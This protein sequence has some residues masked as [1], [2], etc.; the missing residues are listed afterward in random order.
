AA[1]SPARQAVR[2]ASSSRSSSSARC[3]IWPVRA[4][5]CS[6]QRKSSSATFNAA[7][8]ASRVASPVGVDAAAACLFSSTYA[9]SR[10]AY[11]G[12][13]VLRIGYRCP[14]I[15]TGITRPSDIWSLVVRRWSLVVGRSS[16]VARQRLEIQRFELPEHLGHA[17]PDDV[18]LF[19]ERRELGR[20]R[21]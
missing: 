3:A 19:L 9:A 1:T 17:R 18:A 6:R 7:S 2:T 10:P 11:S 5:A 20:Q 16:L 13:R 12:S 4:R 14:W 8:T 21:F 15:S